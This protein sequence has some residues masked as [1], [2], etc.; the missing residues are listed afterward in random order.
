VLAGEPP[1]RFAQRTHLEQA[2]QVPYRGAFR[3]AAC[4]PADRG[5]KTRPGFSLAAMYLISART[6]AVW[7]G[8][9]AQNTFSDELCG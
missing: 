6:L 9:A 1:R 4:R 7:G 2:A 8:L 5:A 3:R